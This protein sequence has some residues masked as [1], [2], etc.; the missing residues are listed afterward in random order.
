MTFYIIFFVV[1]FVRTV[2]N[3]AFKYVNTYTH[4]GAYMQVGIWG[5]YMCMYIYN[6]HIYM[7]TYISIMCIDMDIIIIHFDTMHRCMKV[8]IYTYSRRISI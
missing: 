2:Y 4:T 7:Y 8:Y 5:T 1:P 3:P 6:I